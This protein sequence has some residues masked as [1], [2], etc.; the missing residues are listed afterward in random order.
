MQ[1]LERQDLQE[2]EVQRF[3]DKIRRST[4]SSLGYREHGIA[5]SLGKQGETQRGESE[6]RKKVGFTPFSAAAEGSVLGASTIP[7]QCISWESGCWRLLQ[8]VPFGIAVARS[9]N[10]HSK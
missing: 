10:E 9:C 8:A 1:R 3:L 5:T 2:D 7:C 4:H 6:E